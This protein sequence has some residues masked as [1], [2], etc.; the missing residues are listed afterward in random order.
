MAEIPFHITVVGYRMMDHKR[1]EDMREVGITYISKLMKWLG[2]NW[3]EHLYITAE[4]RIP[5]LL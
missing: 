2:G 3:T 4:N 1:N 5:L